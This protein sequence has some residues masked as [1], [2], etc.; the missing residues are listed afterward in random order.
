M[1]FREKGTMPFNIYERLKKSIAEFKFRKQTYYMKIYCIDI[2][3]YSLSIKEDMADKDKKNENNYQ[4]KKIIN[5]NKSIDRIRNSKIL[6]GDPK[7]LE[8]EDK[9]HYNDMVKLIILLVIYSLE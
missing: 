1:P 6:F 7:I 4:K 5:H 8:N 2:S 9:I 3:I